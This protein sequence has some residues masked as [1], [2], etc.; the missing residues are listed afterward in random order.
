MRLLPVNMMNMSLKELCDVLSIY[1]P[2]VAPVM[3]FS[4]LLEKD[5]VNALHGLSDDE[6]WRL[7]YHLGLPVHTLANVKSNYS[8]ETLIILCVH[9]WYKDDLEASW[10]K[11]IAGLRHIG[12]KVLAKKLAIQHNVETP[13]S[14][15]K[16]LTSDPINP[17]GSS[18]DSDVT[19]SPVTSDS[20]P[21]PP[22]S[23]VTSSDHSAAHTPNSAPSDPVQPSA[24]TTHTVAVTNDPFQQVKEDIEQ[25]EDS[26]ADQV[27]QVKEEV[28]HFQENFTSMM[29][30]T[31]SALCKKESEDSEFIEEFRDYLLFL[32]LSKKVA[33]AK[34]FDDRED[35]ILEAKSVRKLL[36]IL[37]R[38]CNYSNYDLLLH[39]IKKFCNTAEKKK[40]QEYCVSLERFEMAT[41]VNVYLIAISAS[42]AISEAFSRMAMKMNKPASECTLHEIRKLKESLTEKAFLHSYSVYIDTIAESSVLVVLRFPPDCI[43]WVLAAVT[44]DFMDTH[45]LTEVSVDGQHLTLYPKLYEEKEELVRVHLLPSTSIVYSLTQCSD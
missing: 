27:Q 8:G 1:S 16:T 2:T 42:P 37:G 45:H 3:A 44:P 39:L 21:I 19:Q 5:V 41:P 23:S 15:A 25:L 17:P 20:N 4:K 22:P 13:T 18:Q 28:E 36:A 31:R 29:S 24:P 10:G 33:H 26:F 12:M 40:M 6:T 38:Y 35:D 11:I 7:F 32:P 9:E 34:F 30:M 14:V 43:G